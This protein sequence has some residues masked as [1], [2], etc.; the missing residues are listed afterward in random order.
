ML[1]VVGKYVGGKVLTAVLVVT[2]GLILI[3]YW[4]L[5]PEQKDAIWSGL[6]NS[7]VWIAFAAAV[8]WAFY[9]VP[10][11]LVRADSNLVSALGLFGYLLIDA[12]ALF[13]L[14]G[15]HVSGTLAWMIVLLA[16]ACAAIY[17]FLVCEYL[18]QQAEQQ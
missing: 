9:F 4:Q 6:R 12:L 5:P 2:S 7:L 14:A 1:A 18:A 10:P 13:W 15:W 11:I 16:M 3:W 17:D 8:P